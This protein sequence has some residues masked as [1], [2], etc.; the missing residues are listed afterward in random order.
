MSGCASSRRQ[1]ATRRARH[2]AVYL[3]SVGGIQLG[4]QRVH[5][6]HELVHVAVRLGHLHGDVVV[7]RQV[8]L[9][10]L[11]A[12]LDVLH[13]R[14]AVVQR[15]LLGKVPDFDAVVEVYFAV[16]ILVD[17]GE[18]LHQRGLTRTVRA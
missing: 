3:P 17:A 15:R 11:D 1:I 14:L 2:G 8:S 18:D 10:R 4:L 7:L 9:D 16:E 6:R 5:A 12:H 13:H